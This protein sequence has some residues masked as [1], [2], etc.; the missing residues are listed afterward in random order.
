MYVYINNFFMFFL[1]LN[2]VLNLKVI[3]INFL[4]VS[5]IVKHIVEQVYSEA[6]NSLWH[7]SYICNRLNSVPSRQ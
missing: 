1:F 2:F 7:M 4:T 3:D 5:T 6:I